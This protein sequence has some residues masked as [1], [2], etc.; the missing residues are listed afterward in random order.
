MPILGCFG[1]N[2][3]VVYLE[4]CYDSSSIVPLD[5]CFGF[6]GIFVPPYEF[7]DFFFSVVRDGDCVDL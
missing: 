2:S 5:K 4:M 7:Q 3:S 1:Y 6:Q